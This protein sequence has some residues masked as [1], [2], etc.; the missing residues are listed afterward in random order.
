MNE[1]YTYIAKEA[2]DAFQLCVV[3]HLKFSFGLVTCIVAYSD[4]ECNL[5]QWYSTLTF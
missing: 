2:I 4:F 3:L 5:S 1:H